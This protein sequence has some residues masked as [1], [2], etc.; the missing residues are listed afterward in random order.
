MSATLFR[1]VVIFGGSCD[2][3]LPGE[4]RGRDGVGNLIEF[5]EEPA[6]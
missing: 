5:V 1:D 4:V 3:L 2:A 6:D